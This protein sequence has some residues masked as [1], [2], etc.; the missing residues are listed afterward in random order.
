MVHKG[1]SRLSLLLNHAYSTS[2]FS[3]GQL[4][5]LRWPGHLD[6]QAF[7]H[8]SLIGFI[9]P[10]LLLFSCV[11]VIYVNILVSLIF[12]CSLDVEYRDLEIFPSVLFP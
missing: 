11:G 8:P 4:D 1:H 6:S 5:F 3:Q 2:F 7:E 12:G 10:V 9:F